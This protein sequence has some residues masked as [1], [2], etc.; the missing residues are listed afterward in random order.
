[1]WRPF[2]KDAVSS[3]ERT[4][5]T[6]ELQVQAELP[7]EIAILHV[8]EAQDEKGKKAYRLWLN[9]SGIEPLHTLPQR[10]PYLALNQY[11]QS[12]EI[13][14]K[15]VLTNVW[16]ISAAYFRPN[17]IK[18]GQDLRQLRHEIGASF[19]LVISDH[20]ELGIPWELMKMSS[21]ERIGAAIATTRWHPVA[22]DDG[23]LILKPKTEH[24]D[25]EVLPFVYSKLAK[26]ESERA[27]LRRNFSGTEV[28]NDIK[29]F[30]SAM[31][32]SRSNVGL[33]YLACHGTF[34]GQ[35]EVGLTE[36]A[37]GSSKDEDK[38]G[39]QRLRYLDLDGRSLQ[40][41][42][43]S[44]TVVFINACDSG[45]HQREA[46]YFQDNYLRGFPELFL[47]KGARGVIGTLAAVKDRP[48]T[49]IAQALLQDALSTSG[50]PVAELLRRARSQAQQAYEQ[51]ETSE[52]LERL[53]YTFS[54]VYYGNPMLKLSVGPN[55]LRDHQ[56]V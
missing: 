16:E 43:H 53:V 10:P 42:L 7:R 19:C 39:N 28:H 15:Q 36:L 49:A 45:W 40:V 37:L 14:D 12:D 4:F 33:V 56:D 48:A 27:F 1:M 2:P 22:S 11:I 51:N 6:K 35:E 34:F 31:C 46:D 52:N 41:L 5:S 17:L 30:R 47:A 18:L 54:Y 32:A 29:R 50:Q 44:R 38:D 8:Y 26:A 55:A 13:P 3:I 9:G 23:A 21:N 20:T 25:R 24:T